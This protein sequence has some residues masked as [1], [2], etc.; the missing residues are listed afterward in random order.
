[1]KHLFTFLMLFIASSLLAQVPKLEGTIIHNGEA[2]AFASVYLEKQKT[3]TIS[4][5]NGRFTLTDLKLGKDILRVTAVD[6]LSF[7]EEIEIKAENQ[8]VL[9]ELTPEVQNL[10]EIVITGVTRQGKNRENPLPITAISA[11]QIDRLAES[12]VVD[13]LAKYSPGLQVVKTGP[14]ISKPFIRGLGYNRVLTLV[15]G[16]RQEGQQWGDE[17]GLEVDDYNLA[18]AEVIKGPASLLFGSDALAGVVS[19][20]SKEE[21]KNDGKLHGRY[22]GEYHTNNGLIGNGLQLTYAKN[23]WAF[24]AQSSY[25]LAKN[26]RNA[27]DGPVY[28]TN[29]RVANFAAF[30]KHETDKGKTT[31]RF[32]LYDNI[33]GIPDGSRDSVTRQFTKQIYED[34]L[35]DDDNRPIVSK[36]ELTSYKVP[37]LS[38]RIQHYRIIA[39][40]QYEIGKGL[41]DVQ[42]AG[43]QNRRREYNHPL[44]PD[45]PGMHVK[46]NTLN[47][48]IRYNLP[49]FHGIEMIVGANG[50]A[51]NN[52]NIDASEI[53]IPDYSLFDIGTFIYINWKKNRW[54]ISGGAR[55]D[56]RQQKWDNYH[57]GTDPETGFP[58]HVDAD[59]PG[60]EL[61]FPAFKKIF[62]DWSASVGTTFE[63]TPYLYLKANIGRAFR[64]PS[65]NELASNGLDPGAAI[66]YIGNREFSPEYSFQ[67]DLGLS[68]SYAN[69]SAEMNIFHNQVQNFIFLSA[70]PDENGFPLTDNQGNRTYEYKQAKAQLYGGEIWTD[71]H[72]RQVPGLSFKNTFTLVYG[73]N[74]DE[75]FRG[76]GEK[77]EFLPLIPPFQWRSE[78]SYRLPLNVK[79]LR[80]LT[81]RFEVEYAG[82][83]DRFLGLHH[84]ET[85]TDAYFLFNLGIG[86]EIFYAKSNTIGIYLQANNLFDKAYHSHLSR[87]KYLE[88][89]EDGNGIY[90]MGRNISLKVIFNF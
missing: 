53:P 9:V 33:Q 13:V 27:I 55:Y 86:T 83:Q 87:L 16:V 56:I 63:I 29:Y 72:P 12:N 45:Q 1:M 50:M 85:A 89:Y 3:G 59:F 76:S 82:K 67:Q 8:D 71:L 84:T 22:I 39:H 34:D 17:H 21:E 20:Y 38:Q 15:D 73:F 37:A 62:Q 68:A 78:L 6:Y 35:D 69:W 28:L 57:L 88:D 74:R 26:Y 81:P 5:E 52:T 19:L 43:Q 48:G 66:F 46:L 41:I 65:I 61:T 2:V 14:N 42:L 79:W 64:A 23:N 40:S 11:Q 80:Y 30:A 10:E 60:A 70:V 25:K 47:Y 32:T 44:Y 31:L 7:K 18:R 4:D 51:Q 75:E 24:G 58:Q 54:T 36:E 90:N 77:G 49:K